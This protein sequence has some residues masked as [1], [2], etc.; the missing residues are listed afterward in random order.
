MERVVGFMIQILICVG[1]LSLQSEYP[2][3]EVP[4]AP[5]SFS[6]VNLMEPDLLMVF[7]W[8]VNFRTPSFFTIFSTSSTYLSHSFGLQT[9]GAVAIAFCSKASMKML[10]A[11]GNTGL[12][13]AVPN[14]WQ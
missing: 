5:V 4:K 9:M 7:M 2:E 12:P 11:M 8:S 10:A 13:V 14:S 3:M 1:K 6:Y